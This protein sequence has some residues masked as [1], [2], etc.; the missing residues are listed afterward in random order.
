MSQS[1]GSHNFEFSGLQLSSSRGAKNN[2]LENGL[3]NVLLSK[4]QICIK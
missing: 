3:K 4:A 1:F 2:N